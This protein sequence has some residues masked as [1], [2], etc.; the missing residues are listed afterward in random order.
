M[1]LHNNTEGFENAAF[2]RDA[3]YA[4]TTGRYNT[5]TGNEALSRNTEGSGNIAVGFMALYQAEGS[6]NTAVGRKAAVAS[7]ILNNCTILGSEGSAENGITNATAVGYRAYVSASN[8]VRIGDYE[9]TSIGGAVNWS[10][11]SD[12]R[13]KQDVKEE[14]RGLPFIN[15]LRPVTYFLDVAAIDNALKAGRPEVQS[16]SNAALKEVSKVLSAEQPQVKQ[17]QVK[18]LYTGFVAQEV[19]QAARE[20]NYEFSGVDKPKNEKNFYGLRYAA[21]VVPLVKAV[22]ELDTKNRKLEEELAGLKQMVMDL[23]NG[24]NSHNS[25]SLTVTTAYLEQNIPNPTAG[26]TTIRYH[27][28]A[29][30]HAAQ[31]LLTNMTGQTVK[32]LDLDSQG[33]GTVT[34]NTAALAAG[35]Y[36]YSLFVDGQQAD[37]R[38]LVVVR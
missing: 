30:S 8:Q 23:K 5:A 25:Y 4:N 7:E 20:L 36:T 19:E 17:E 26:T 24:T 16:S 12:G 35:V 34:I 27:L 9:V 2:G 15:K 13:F 11:L 33:S 22:Q 1:A 31:L 21:F 38:R 6:G 10:T 32:R 18:V 3:L 14:V 28:P 29:N 37:A